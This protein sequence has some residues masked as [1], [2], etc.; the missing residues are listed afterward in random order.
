MASQD[1]EGWSGTSSVAWAT[2]CS[3]SSISCSGGWY[4][5]DTIHGW[6]TAGKYWPP[7]TLKKK[8][9][10]LCISKVRP[11]G[12]RNSE[13]GFR[14]GLR[15]LQAPIK[16]LV[17]ALEEECKDEEMSDNTK[18]GMPIQGERYKYQGR[19]ANAKRWVRALEIILAVPSKSILITR[20]EYFYSSSA[21]EPATLINLL[22]LFN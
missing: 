9:Q 13:T 14:I 10:P 19:G 15:S 16:N 21:W 2:I 3:R 1:E 17:P 22:V 8:R 7:S 12:R 18:K 5:N 6:A 20:D 11:A 4:F